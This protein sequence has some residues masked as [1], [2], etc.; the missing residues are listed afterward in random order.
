MMLGPAGFIYRRF[1][2][3]TDPRGNRSSNHELLEMIFMAITATI[4]GAD[5]WAEVE[6]FVKAQVSC[7]AS[8]PAI[9]RR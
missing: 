7:S 8:S 6:R 1:E 3:M 9:H 4:C 5:G 2:R